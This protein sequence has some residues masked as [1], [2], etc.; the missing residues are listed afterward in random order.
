MNIANVYLDCLGDE[1]QV[2]NQDAALKTRHGGQAA[3]LH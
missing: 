3:A 2:Q 1:R